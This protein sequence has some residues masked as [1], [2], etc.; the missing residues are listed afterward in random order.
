MTQ[1]TVHMTS[2]MRS[3]DTILKRG[4]YGSLA[5]WLTRRND[6]SLRVLSRELE[7]LTGVRCD[8]TAISGYYR[9]LGIERIHPP[10]SRKQI[11]KEVGA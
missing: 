1:E 6:V 5:E 4:K 9:H 2:R 8:Y 3:L 11:A 7:A 10:H